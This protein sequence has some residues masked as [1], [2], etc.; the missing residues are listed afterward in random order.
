MTTNIH[1]ACDQMMTDVDGHETGTGSLSTITTTPTFSYCP[2]SE[3]SYSDRQST[4]CYQADIDF[5]MSPDLLT[6]NLLTTP[7]NRLSY[8]GDLR[9]KSLSNDRRSFQEIK[10]KN[11]QDN[12]HYESFN[13]NKIKEQIKSDI[14]ILMSSPN[15]SPQKD[16]SMY[17]IVMGNNYD[18]LGSKNSILHQDD[19]SYEEVMPSCKSSTDSIENFNF[20]IEKSDENIQYETLVVTSPESCN[21]SQRE[22][23]VSPQV[24]EIN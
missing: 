18:R 19:S 8:Q 13:N 17:K 21:S 2:L 9:N 4:T 5:T 15:C 6:K 11:V 10:L 3:D 7:R 24:M 12:C 20:E 16:G 1:S 23:S 14:S 22:M